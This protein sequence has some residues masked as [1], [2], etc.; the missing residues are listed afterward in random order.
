MKKKTEISV[1]FF[2][3]FLHCFSKKRNTFPVFLGK[4]G[5]QQTPDLTKS[6]PS[7]FSLSCFGELAF[8]IGTHFLEEF[9]VGEACKKLTRST[10]TL[11]GTDGE[12]SLATTDV[13]RRRSS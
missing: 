2:C 10:S 6:T 3:V 11:R 8:F 9:G 1:A 12:E 7:D 13:D 4:E 5:V